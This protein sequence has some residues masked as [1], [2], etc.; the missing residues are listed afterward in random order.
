MGRAYNGT[1]FVHDGTIYVFFKGGKRGD[2]P[3]SLYVSTD[4]GETFQQRSNHLFAR[5]LNSKNYWYLTAT[6]LPDGRFIVYA[7]QGPEDEYN[8][9]YVISSDQG[10]TWSD[11]GYSF[12]EKKI[13]N[14]QISER[15]GEYY[16]IHGRTGNRGYDTGNFVLYK[17]R[18]G[19]NWDSGL[20]LNRGEGVAFPG[21]DAYSGNAVVGRHD[22]SRPLRLLIQASVS[23]CGSRVNVKHWWIENIPGTE[24]E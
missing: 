20:F 11:V 12:F 19:L 7:Y 5:R 18:D 23:Y 1:S 4:N 9:P 22:P 8:A 10:R 16:F 14:P 17:S 21:S 15:I 2:G 3:I 13:R 6:V 24:K